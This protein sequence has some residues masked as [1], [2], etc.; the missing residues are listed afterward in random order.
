MREP[1]ATECSFCD[2]TRQEVK[3]LI[4]RKGTRLAICDECIGL[5]ADILLRDKMTSG[6]LDG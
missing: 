6:G 2:K 4:Q 5:C 1:R 3:R